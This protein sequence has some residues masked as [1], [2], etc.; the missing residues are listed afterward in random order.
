[1]TSFGSPIVRVCCVLDERPLDIE[2]LVDIM[3]TSKSNSA[4]DIELYVVAYYSLLL[5]VLGTIL[6][7]L[8]FVVFFRGKFRNTEERP[9][10]HYMRAIAIVDILM[11]Y[12]WNL[13]H[14]LMNVHG[15]YA[16]S[17][18]I[19][20][21]KLVLFINYFAPQTS[22]WLRVAICLDRYLSLSRLH[23]TWFG[24]S[25]HVLICTFSYSPASTIPT[26]QS[27]PNRSS[28]T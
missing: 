24:H 13:D 7:L 23:R 15:Y 16:S 12:G 4:A 1:V 17:V 26:V 18:S 28:M 19:G 14:Y 22:A 10:I 27:M 11:L 9:T 2:H 21:C 3:A 25:K 5:M 6:N 8:T 20:I